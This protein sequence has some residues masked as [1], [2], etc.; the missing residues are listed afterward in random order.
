MNDSDRNK[1]NM[2]S[3]VEVVSQLTVLYVAGSR[4]VGTTRGWGT[5]NPE[6]DPF[7]V[8]LESNYCTLATKPTIYL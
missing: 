6:N 3:K 4:F 5:A 2:K 1:K 7:G 8:D